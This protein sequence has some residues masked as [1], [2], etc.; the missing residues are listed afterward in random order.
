MLILAAGE[1]SIGYQKRKQGNFGA[2]LGSQ[3]RNGA[4][5]ARLLFVFDR[6][7]GLGSFICSGVDLV[8]R[9]TL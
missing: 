9:K 6:L 8:L 2:D 1:P 5:L 3:H 4:L 7:S